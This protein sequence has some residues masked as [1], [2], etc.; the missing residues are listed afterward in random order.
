MTD[1]LI[2]GSSAK[3]RGTDGVEAGGSSPSLEAFSGWYHYIV[4]RESLTP[5]QLLI[6][7]MHAAR[8]NGARHA[9][10]QIIESFAGR[11]VTDDDVREAVGRLFEKA[12]PPQ[13]TRIAFLVAT[14]A[15][16]AKLIGDLTAA[17]IDFIQNKEVAGDLEGKVTSVSFMTK[18]KAA[19]EPIVGHLPKGR[20][21]KLAPGEEF[22]PDITPVDR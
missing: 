6:Q 15:R 2:P 8:D 20:L 14:K 18:D 19:V 11:N 5:P 13:D 12:M 1:P 3:E 9:L 22:D 4:V 17:K 7:A 21:L 16:L 10:M